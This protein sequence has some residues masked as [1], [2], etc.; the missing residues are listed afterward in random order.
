MDAETDADSTRDPD[1]VAVTGGN[2]TLGRAVVARLN[3]AG[4]RTVNL[5]RGKS[6]AAEADG[7]LRTDL[8][9]AGEVY[10]SLA[11]SGADAVAHLG[12]LPTPERTPGHV[13]FRSNA[14]GAYHVLE[15]AAAL[16]VGSVAL[17][18]SLSA[19]GAGF[20]PDPIDVRYL[21][22]DE[23]HPATPTNPYGIGKLAAETAADGFGRRDGP[24]RTIS[25]LRFPWVVT[26][27]DVA[28]TFGGDRS[29]AG[30]R[31]GGHFATARDTLFSYVHVG[32]AARAVERALTAGF[33]GHE[34]FFPVAADTTTTTPSARLAEEVYPDATAGDLE[35]RESLLSG[36]K[37]ADALGWRPGRSWRG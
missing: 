35:G 9:D 28:A 1:V 24:P 3:E 19:L 2:G 22:V 7:Y 34:R 6:D 36:R 12:A 17:A 37:A 30:I 21:P 31:A 13:T 8:L 23:D 14:L 10:G 25:S 20:D 29:L 15:A 26:P 32:D 33:D 5:S 27:E 11:R 16:G 4:Y 18:S